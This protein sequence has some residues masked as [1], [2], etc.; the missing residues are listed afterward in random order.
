VPGAVLYR[1]TA[2]QPC[3]AGAVEPTL[4]IGLGFGM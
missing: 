1:F 3:V 2:G 4:G